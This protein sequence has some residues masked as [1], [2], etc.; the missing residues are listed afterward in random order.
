MSKPLLKDLRELVTANIITSDT[1]DQIA[2]YYQSK[3]EAPGEKFNIVL[4]I[5]GALLV[6]FG[7]VLLVAHN[8]DV[9]PRSVQTIFAF[10]PLAAGQALCVFTLLKKRTNVAWRES[11][12]VILFFAVASCMALISQIYHINGTLDGFILTWLLLT[13]ALVYMM[14]S[15]LVSLLVIACATWYATLVGYQNIFSYHHTDIPYFYLVF[16]AFIGPHYYQYFKSNRKSNFFHLHNWFLVISTVIALGAFAG[17][18]EDTFQW[19]FIGYCSLFGIYYLL[20]ESVYFEESRLFANPFL[21]AGLLGTIIIF[22]FWS[23]DGIWNELRGSKENYFRDLFQS[24]F[25]YL[26]FLLLVLHIYLLINLSKAEKGLYNPLRLSVYVFAVAVLF[27]AQIPFLGL[28]IMNAWVLVTAMFYIRKGAIKDHLGILNFGLL[29]IA[30]LTLLRFFDDSI[31]FVWRGLFFVAT[32][33]GFFLANYL[34]LKKRKS[35]S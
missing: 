13:A 11:S 8:W 30:C 5:L 26:S 20:G 10:L 3:K 7:I 33:I 12:S 29:I 18:S 16:L 35:I 14:R 22:L 24:I 25:F 19:I 1:A 17:K 27:F 28:L 15:S 4:G 34:I 6:G 31:A 32:G 23:Y 9:M 2:R 21:I